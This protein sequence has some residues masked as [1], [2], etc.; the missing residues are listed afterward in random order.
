MTTLFKRCVVFFVYNNNN[1]NNNNNNSV[2]FK[3]SNKIL[4]IFLLR[5]GA[6]V[7][8]YEVPFFLRLEVIVKKL[9]NM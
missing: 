2:W 9:L 3:G 5:F 7:L 1:N 4:D 6:V 8:D